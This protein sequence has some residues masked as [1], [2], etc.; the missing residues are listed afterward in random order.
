M[1]LGFEA[2]WRHRVRVGVGVR[3]RVR[4]RVGLRVRGGVETS[5]S[6]KESIVSSS[7]G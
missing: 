5:G 3:V 2:A 6:M 7:P 4:L 1:G